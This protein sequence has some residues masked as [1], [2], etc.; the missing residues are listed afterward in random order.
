MEDFK[1][2]SGINWKIIWKVFFGWFITLVI[3]GSSTGLLIA[4]GI[5]APTEN[6]QC[7]NR[8]DI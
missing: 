5:Y 3:V 1:K 7:S 4:Q 8:T 2:C 6:N